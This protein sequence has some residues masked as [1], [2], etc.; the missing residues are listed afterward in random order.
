MFSLLKAWKCQKSKLRY[1]RDKK[2]RCSQPLRWGSEEK[3]ERLRRRGGGGGGARPLQRGG[4]PRGWRRGHQERCELESLAAVGIN[5]QWRVEKQ[6]HLRK[7]WE[8][9]RPKQKGRVRF[10]STSSSLPPAPPTGATRSRW[11]SGFAK[12]DLQ[13]PSA[14]HSGDLGSIPGLGRSLREGKGN[15]L[16]YS[17]LEKSMDSMESQRVGHDLVTFTV[18]EP[19]T[20]KCTWSSETIA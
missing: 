11:R 6:Q 14:C 1:Y 2:R 19:S 4:R 13:S 8:A 5:R 12:G 18:S 17:G 16:Q 7:F 10:P 9:A 3:V 15:P 20:E